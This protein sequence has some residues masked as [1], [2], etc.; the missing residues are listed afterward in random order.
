[1]RGLKKD[2]EFYGEE[3]MKE[4]K[5][6][7]HLG[8]YEKIHSFGRWLNTTNDI[9]SRGTYLNLLAKTARQNISL[10]SK[11]GAYFKDYY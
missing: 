6:R 5:P 2:Q 11:V 10:E 1:M 3:E 9:I 8:T 7:K 4:G